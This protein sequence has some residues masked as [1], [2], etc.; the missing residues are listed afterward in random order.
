MSQG[1]GVAQGVGVGQGVGL[2]HFVGVGPGL[3]V[4]VPLGLGEGLAV[5]GVVV[6]EPSEILEEATARET[7]RRAGADAPIRF[8]NSGGI[9]VQPAAKVS[10]RR[11]MTVFE[12]NCITSGHL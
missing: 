8:V 12:R 1:V 5:L 2:G 4:S 11:V 9:A 7:F 6:A 10:S 3:G